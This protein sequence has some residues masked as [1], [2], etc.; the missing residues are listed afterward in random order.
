[1]RVMV[2]SWG[3][4][5]HFYPMVP[6]AQQMRAAGHDVRVVTQPQLVPLARRTGLPVLPTDSYL[7]ARALLGATPE[8][9]GG[10][11]A[12]VP[13]PVVCGVVDVEPYVRI[14]EANAVTTL[15]YARRWRP[16]L[17]MYE[18]STYTGPIV[19]AAV[20][21]PAVRHL[22]GVDFMQRFHTVEPYALAALCARLDLPTVETLGDLTID[23]CPP[24]MQTPDEEFLPPVRR[25]HTRF[26]PYNGPAVLPDWL[27]RPPER[28]RLCVTW[29]TTGYS[30]G[31]Y[32]DTLRRVVDTMGEL[33]A[34]VVVTLSP[35]DAAEIGATAPNVRLV[36]MVALH[37]LLPTCTGI[38]AQGGLGTMMTAAA[39]GVPA[40]IIPQAS[41]HV[42]NADRLAATGAGHVL[43]FAD[44]TAPAILDA[45]RALLADG[46]TARAAT[47]LADE[48]AAQT[49]LVDTV[50]ALGELAMAG[51][52]NQGAWVRPTAPPPTTRHPL[53]AAVASG[54][55]LRVLVT[56]PRWSTAT[57]TAMIP[58]VHALRLAGYDVLVATT[59]EYAGP[60]ARCGLPTVAV[61]RPADAA[62]VIGGM[63]NP[64]TDKAVE[65]QIDKGMSGLIGVRSRMELPE[66]DQGAWAQA[67]RDRHVDAIRSA[68]VASSSVIDD[69]LA[70]ARAWRPDLIVFGPNSFA[71]PL[72]AAILDVPSVRHLTWADQSTVTSLFEQEAL[73][74]LWERHGAGEPDPYGTLTVDPCPLALRFYAEYAWRPVRY[75]PHLGAAVPGVAIGGSSVVGDRSCVAVAIGATAGWPAAAAAT[76]ATVLDALAGA[77]ATVFVLASPRD[78]D[79][80][81][82]LP[83]NVRQVDPGLLAA[84]LPGCAALVT[85]GEPDALLTA[86]A[87]GCPA[88][89]LPRLPD[90]ALRG[91]LFARVGGGVALPPSAAT[92]G[93]I[94]DAV[95]TLVDD[96]AF[97]VPL[98]RMA[99]EMRAKPSYDDV[100]AE[101]GELL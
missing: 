66:A 26:R 97:R 96:D 48:I 31:P 77:V 30:R 67:W 1:M 12:L 16:D 4:A 81:V 7:D 80:I 44:A 92:P 20:G 52:Q 56:L 19:A 25:I 93:A 79:A 50:T 65:I 53:R 98:R 84:V 32:L 100:V 75:V 5:T 21:V 28:R 38:I 27:R 60:A 33:D 86:V 42:L 90:Q 101:I 82:A 17:V 39:I 37:L 99:E 88:L 89:V 6:L 73:A 45:T 23:V 58:F 8:R 64:G 13:A 14:A 74:P 61:G 46:S 51:P 85:A 55:V 54:R 94:R 34:E 72:A 41:D 15:S 57:G 29:G 59:P 91:H 35:E 9:R 22:W 70:L 87:S 2:T 36:S 47:A 11:E 83:D 95:A 78:R 40:L 69:T 24:R 63:F 18:P 49:S 71:G 43:P 10:P 68:L 76:V 62:A 3:A